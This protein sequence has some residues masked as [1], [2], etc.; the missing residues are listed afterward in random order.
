M[1][2]RKPVIAAI[3]GP[4]AGMAIPISLSCDLRF[5][6]DEAVFT[7]AFSRRGLVAE[8][9]IG[10]LLPRL[11][12]PAVALD[13]LFSARK[14]DAAE[15]LQIGL[16]NRVVPGADLMP[17]VLAYARDLAE[18]C[19]P[20][21]MRL[22]KRQVYES[23]HQSLGPAHD[24]AVRLMIESFDRPDFKEGVASFLQKRPP[25]FERV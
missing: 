11:V 10:W 8:W 24:T 5:A 1:S 2:L 25:K 12:G 4:C 13:L 6:A 3:N 16:V 7:T 15:A 21:S 22:M 9:G 14:V 23:L 19:S 20:T 17:T 18:N